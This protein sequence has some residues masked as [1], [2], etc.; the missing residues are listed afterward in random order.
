[1]VCATEVNATLLYGKFDIEGLF[2]EIRLPFSPIVLL[3]KQCQHRRQ[4]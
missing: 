4:F 2:V 1:M 3:I